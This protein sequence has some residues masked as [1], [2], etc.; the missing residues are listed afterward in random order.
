M[1]EILK[2]IIENYFKKDEVKELFSYDLVLDNSLL[3]IKSKKQDEEP[4]DFFYFA[5]IDEENFNN[6]NDLEIFKELK[7]KKIE[8][9]SLNL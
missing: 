6:F 8:N 5:F 3:I 2:K 9:D 1:K 7:E 4:S